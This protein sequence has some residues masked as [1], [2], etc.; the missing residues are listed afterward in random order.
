MMDAYGNSTNLMHP[1]RQRMTI[2][3]LNLLSSQ[4]FVPLM[5]QLWA[6]TAL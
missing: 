3:E 4:T 6:R 1:E 5:E 2:S